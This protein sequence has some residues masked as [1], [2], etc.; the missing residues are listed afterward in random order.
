MRVLRWFALV[1]VVA[2]VA[3]P[4]RAADD[5][6]QE[7][8]QVESALTRIAQDQQSVYQQFQM[9]QGMLRGEEAKM[10]PLQTYTPPVNPPNY[11]D[12]MR[13]DESRKARIR[14]YQDELDRLYSRYR[15]LEEQRTDLTRTLSALAQQRSKDNGR[16]TVP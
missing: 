4:V 8:R 11:D 14:Q 16:S 6:E 1:V 13:E 15:E 7:M 12:I 2:S 10:Q 9:V 3:V 5:V